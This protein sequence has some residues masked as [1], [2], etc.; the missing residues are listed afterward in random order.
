MNQGYGASVGLSV[1]LTPVF[2]PQLAQADR[3]SAIIT[4]KNFK[5]YTV[6][7]LSSPLKHPAGKGPDG[8]T[9]TGKV[10]HRSQEKAFCAQQNVTLG[11]TFSRNIVEADSVPTHSI[12]RGS[13]NG[14]C[15]EKTKSPTGPTPHCIDPETNSHRGEGGSQRPP[16]SR[17]HAQ[18]REK[19]SFPGAA[20]TSLT[21][22]TFLP[23]VA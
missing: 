17:E 2:S 18:A 23:S 10:T 9:R 15:E 11:H 12:T 6:L 14:A 7:P 13:G 4:K 1:G 19:P 16:V 5:G 20:I 22:L 8:H 3:S 21:V